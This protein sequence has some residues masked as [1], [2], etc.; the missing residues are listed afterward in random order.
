MSN[1]KKSK[2]L[3]M[4]FGTAGARLKRLIIW[5]LLVELNLEHCYR[6]EQLMSVDTYSID[7]DI[8]WLDNDVELF[9]DITNIRYSH[10]SCN[11]Q[12]SSR[13]DKHCPEENSWCSSCKECR[14][15]F[16]FGNNKRKKNGLDPYC[17][18]C[19]RPKNA[20]YMRNKRKA[21]SVVRASD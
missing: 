11:V 21:S 10:L 12:A 14:P 7:H 5:S 2:Q 18:K 15:T 1:D 3:G 19:K 6:C 17:K 4:S 16:E 9:W 20:K 8:N 13:N